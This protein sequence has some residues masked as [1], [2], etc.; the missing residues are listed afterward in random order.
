VGDLLRGEG[1]SLQAN[2]K[3]IE[4]TQHPDRDAQFRYINGQARDHRDAGEPVISV[5][6]KE[7][8]LVGQ[9]KNGDREWMPKGEP[10]KVKTHDFLDRQGPGRAIPYGIYDVVANT[11]WVSVGTDH[12]TAAFAVAS[13]RRWW[14]PV[15]GTRTRRPPGCWS[16]PAR[17]A[18]TATA[19]GPGR[20]NSPGW[21]PRPAWTSPCATCRPA[22]NAVV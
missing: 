5:D 10:V 6:T 15:A 4:G 18:P 20:P 1:F 21:P 16:P 8:E 14:Q 12:D 22:H 3:T 17:A 7:K 19:P 13:I 2:A 11:G 9:Y